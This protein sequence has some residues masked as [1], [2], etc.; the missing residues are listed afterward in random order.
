MLTHPLKSTYGALMTLNHIGLTVGDLDQAIDFY[1]TVFGLTL[2]VGAETATRET[3]GADRRAEVFGERWRGMRLAHLADENGTGVELF[4]FL[5]LEP[6][7]PA[8][9]FDYWRIGVS[10]FAFTTPD[11]EEVI[12]RLEANGGKARTGIHVVR[13]G[14]RICYCADPWGN[15]VELSTG[16]YRQTH[17]TA[18][19]A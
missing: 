11:L 6:A 1:T 13:P 5:E 16:T 9:H 3:A 7:Y 12:A 15:A 18:A 2:L 8:E 14:C 17:P 4:Q 10:H 19:G